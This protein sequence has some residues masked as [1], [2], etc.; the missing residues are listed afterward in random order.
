MFDSRTII[1]GILIVAFGCVLVARL[2]HLQIVNGETYQSD[3]TMQIRRETSIP[4][5]RGCIYDSAGNLLAYNK[6]S[7]DVTF[8][9]M[10]TYETTRER[11]L[12]INSYLYK[13]MQIL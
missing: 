8:Q 3:F 2:F 1:L 4:S 9:D 6:L 5:T 13:I 10:G 11:N 7:Y 12:T